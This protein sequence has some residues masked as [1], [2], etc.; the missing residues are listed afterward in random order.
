MEVP[1]KLKSASTGISRWLVPL[2]FLATAIFLVSCGGTTITEDVA[3]TTDVGDI[4]LTIENE[5]IAVGGVT[6]TVTAEVFDIEGNPVPDGTTVNFTVEPIGSM[7]ASASTSSG[8]ARTILTSGIAAGEYTVTASAGSAKAIAVGQFIAGQASAANTTLSANPNSID[9]DGTSTSIIT[10]VA[11]DAYNNPVSDDTAVDFYTN[12]GSLSAATGTTANGIATVTLTSS[13]D[14]NTVATVTADIGF[15]LEVQVGFGAVVVGGEGSGTANTIVLN[16][17]TN[18]IRVKNSGGNETTVIEATAKDE[19]GAPITDCGTENNI[20]FAIINGPGG[21]EKLDSNGLSVE[22]STVNGV[23]TATLSSGTVSGS[24]NVQVSVILNGDCTV[25]GPDLPPS[26][27]YATAFSSKIVIEA[28]EPANVTIFQDNLVTANNDGS[29]SQTF[30][31]LVEDLHGNP[32]ENGTAV[33]FGLVDNPNSDVPPYFGYLSSGT[34]GAANGTAT[35]TSPTG[36]FVADGVMAEDILI[37]LGGRNEGGHRIASVNNNTSVTLYNTLNVS[38]TG[39]N[40]L[41]GS[42]ELGTVCGF[43][44]TG[45]LERDSSCTPTEVGGTGSIKGVA[46]TT[47]TWVPQG[48]FRPFNLYAESVGGDVGDTWADNYPAVAPVTV[49]VT[50]APSSVRSG[51]TGIAVV[52]EIKDGAGNP[53][54]GENVTFSSS[55]PG[56]AFISGASPVV[57]DTSGKASTTIDTGICLKANTNVTITA[58][59]GSFVGTNTLAVSA[60]APT[61]NFT[62]STAAGTPLGTATY[63]DTSTTPAGTTLTGW[64]WIFNGGT[65][66][67]DSTSIHLPQVNIRA[68]DISNNAYGDERP[69]MYFKPGE[70]RSNDSGAVRQRHFPINKKPL[71]IAIQGL[72]VIF[73]LS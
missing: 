14:D 17:A 31:A 41:A 70:Q 37:I 57:T 3:V 22:K 30:S 9:A 23:A 59:L 21:G 7:P 65:P 61:A 33:Y 43:A 26:G 67:A 47:V 25:T 72:F 10:L 64:S 24:V 56:T 32:V 46:H 1:E 27:Y 45:N 53:I 20:R 36:T 12:R 60:T 69:G 19:T 4:I 18:S 6:T 66:A 28:G 38:E 48:I 2:L 49:T 73:Y 42:S 11:R 16:I 35:F 15:M 62:F 55:N 39:L 63:T 34:D 50:I 5:A 52:A 13:T 8:I 68:R 51:E 54:Q 58:A 40:Y 44:Q 29:I 71:D